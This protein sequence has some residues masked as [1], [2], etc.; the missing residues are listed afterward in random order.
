MPKAVDSVE[1]KV[2][3]LSRCKVRHV[4]DPG[5]FWK[6]R[7]GESFVAEVDGFV[8]QVD[9]LNIE[10]FLHQ[11]MHQTACATGR[12]EKLFRFAAQELIVDLLNEL[13]FCG[14]VGPENQIV[15]LRIV[16]NAFGDRFH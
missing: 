1:C 5:R 9:A 8:V 11:A 14:A 4:R 6:I 7:T 12:L 15:V 3:F 13:H 10:T 16:V 2:V